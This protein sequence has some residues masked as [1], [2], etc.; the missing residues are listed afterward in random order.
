MSTVPLISQLKSAWQFIT[1]DAEGAKDTWH[2]FTEAWTQHPGQTIA[3][4]TDSIPLIGHIKGI[5]THL[6]NELLD[7]RPPGIVHFV[8]GERDQFWQ[9]EEQ[10]T[11]TL[12][13]IG[14]GALT[15]STGGAAA[16][17]LAGVVA[18]LA[19]DGVITGMSIQ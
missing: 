18:G 4:M 1:G 6:Y 10:A 9:S 8:R 2:Q 16:P 7:N 5:C 19:Y 17:V 14:A 15:V 12:V 13:V 3:N 11:R